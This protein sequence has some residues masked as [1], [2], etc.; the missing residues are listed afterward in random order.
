YWAVAG[1]VMAALVVAVAIRQSRPRTYEISTV[2]APQEAPQSPQPA[3][4]SAPLAR[5][6]AAELRRAK[7]RENKPL[8]DAAPKDRE[9]ER[10]ANAPPAAARVPEAAPQT[11]YEAAAA[12]VNKLK[13]AVLDFDSA[14]SQAKDLDTTRADVGKTA[15]DLLT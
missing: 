2:T 8:R 4:E 5:D 6:P 14:D 3:Q 1:S 15:S 13:L 11:R 9:A 12:P 7:V 10:F